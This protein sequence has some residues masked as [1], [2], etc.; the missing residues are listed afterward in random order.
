MH[1]NGADMNRNHPF[2]DAVAVLLAEWPDAQVVIRPAP[3]GS[4][5]DAFTIHAFEVVPAIRGSGL[6]TRLLLHVLEIADR[7]GVNLHVEPALTR[8]GVLDLGL[9]QWYARAGFVWNDPQ[10]PL[11]DGQMHRRSMPAMAPVLAEA[12]PYRLPGV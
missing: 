8:D 10:D 1:V 11:A 7:H 12:S 3:F 2:A 9:A 5:P 6:G 4:D